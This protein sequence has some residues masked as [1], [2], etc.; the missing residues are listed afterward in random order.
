MKFTACDKRILAKGLTLEC[1]LEKAHD[2]CPLNALRHLPTEQ[3]NATING[4]TDKQVDSIMQIHKH[5]HH[6]S[7]KAQKHAKQ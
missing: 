2:D 5:C 7:L 4:L 3:V 1:P 6:D